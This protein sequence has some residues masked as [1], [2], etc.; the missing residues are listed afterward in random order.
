MNIYGPHGDGARST[1]AWAAYLLMWLG[2]LLAN[3]AV[4]P[5]VFLIMAPSLIN[6]SALSMESRGVIIIVTLYIM[7]SVFALLAVLWIKRYERR[8]L[9][10]AGLSLRGSFTAA[11]G[12]YARGLLWGLAFA[13]VLLLVGAVLGELSGVTA[14]KNI[15]FSTQI[16][17]RPSTILV[18][19]VLVVGLLIQSAAEEII[20]R[21]W[22][23][24]TLVARHGRLIGLL[25]SSVFFGTLHVHFLFTDYWAAGLVAIIS[26]TLMGVM[27]GLYAMKQRSVIGAC[28]IHG[29]F[30]TVIFAMALVLALATGENPNALAGLQ[31]AY[32]ASTQP[33]SLTVVSFAQGGVA[34]MAVIF[35]WWRMRA[36]NVSPKG[37]SRGPKSV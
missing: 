32:E 4:L 1:P 18:F 13:L 10:S 3:M 28:G 11:L 5:F 17:S 14:Q 30:N 25:L 37:F 36:K 23:L 20:C 24:S 31:S 35:L 21:G 16:F 12:R 29:A 27:L 19:A 9:A 6:G 22:L 2:W 33:E 34:L 15:N 8:A 26:V 7:F